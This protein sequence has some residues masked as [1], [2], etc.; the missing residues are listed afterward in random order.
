M[1]TTAE[2]VTARSN[3][4]KRLNR[5][6]LAKIFGIRLRSVAAVFLGGSAGLSLT[7]TVLPTMIEITGANDSFSARLDLAGLAV[8]A[9]MLWGVGGWAARKTGRALAGAIIL[10][11]V[12]LTSA[13]VFTGMV[14]GSTH[15]EL[16]LL[17]ASAGMAYGAIGGMLI[18][19]ALAEPKADA[20]RQE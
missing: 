19:A 9:I 5:Y 20:S 14:Y 17:C 4:I 11:L 10:G 16:L 7:S 6:I 13:A 18:A 12:G 1:R 2:P 15:T 3:M 8:Y